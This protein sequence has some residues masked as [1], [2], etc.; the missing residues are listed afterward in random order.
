M[1][2]RFLRPTPKQRLNLCGPEIRRNERT[3]EEIKAEVRQRIGIY[4]THFEDILTKSSE[5]ALNVVVDEE[6][7]L[8]RGL[9]N[10]WNQ[11]ISIA[12]Q[13]NVDK[14]GIELVA[15]RIIELTSE[16][17]TITDFENAIEQSPKSIKGKRLVFLKKLVEV[18]EEASNRKN[19]LYLLL[20]ASPC[21]LNQEILNLM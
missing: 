5:K 1:K 10:R 9:I 17:T 18:T 3:D 13:N 12:R 21:F 8:Y 15:T 16:D 20:S 11:E 7:A 2:P 14:K 4:N 19:I 6:R